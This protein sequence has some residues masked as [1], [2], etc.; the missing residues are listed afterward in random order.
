MKRRDPEFGVNKES[1]TW[2][3]LSLIKKGGV[4]IDLICLFITLWSFFFFFS[5]NCRRLARS[6][7]GLPIFSAISGAEDEHNRTCRSRVNTHHST[8][9]REP[10]D[11]M[12]ACLPLSRNENWGGM[13]M[14]QGQSCKAYAVPGGRWRGRQRKRWEDN[15]R[16]WTGLSFARSQT[17]TH[18]RDQWRNINL[19]HFI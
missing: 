1:L 4:A 17:A 18:D 11:H 12:T 6:N 9:S 2:L 15:I 7:A 8:E 16:E 13:D 14:W 5:I 10:S 3:L 19:I